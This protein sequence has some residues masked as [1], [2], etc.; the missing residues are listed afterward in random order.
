LEFFI[1]LVVLLILM[2]WALFIMR[3]TFGSRR[4]LRMLMVIDKCI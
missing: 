2:L 4:Q 3:S 1:F